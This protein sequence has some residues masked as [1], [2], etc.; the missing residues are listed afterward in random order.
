MCQSTLKMNIVVYKNSSDEFNIGHCPI[1]V[2]VMGKFSSDL[3]KHIF[4]ILY[5]INNVNDVH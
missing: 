1:K 2:K 3:C 5:D 4:L